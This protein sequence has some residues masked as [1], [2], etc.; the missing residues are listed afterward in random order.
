M[1]PAVAREDPPIVSQTF[2]HKQPKTF[3]T[4]PQDRPATPIPQRMATPQ[5]RVLIISPWQGLFLGWRGEIS[6]FFYKGH[7]FQLQ[8]KMTFLRQMANYFL[9]PQGPVA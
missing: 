6:M 8:Y 5:R 7:F 4:A 2:F 9:A 1:Q 3:I